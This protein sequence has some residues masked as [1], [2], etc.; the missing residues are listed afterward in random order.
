LKSLVAQMCIN[1][2]EKP[3]SFM[4]D[5]LRKNYLDS[6]EMDVSADTEVLE[7]FPVKTGQKRQLRAR[8]R[9]GAFSSEATKDVNLDAEPI[10]VVPKSA[11][12]K[13]RLAKALSINILFSH[14]DDAEREEIF[15]AMSEVSFDAGDVII[16]QGDDHGDHFYVVDEGECEIFVTSPQGVRTKVAHVDSGG[17]FGELALIYG[18]SRAADVIA[19]TKV[20]LWAID[21]ITYRRI[22]MGA[23][24]RKREQFRAFL[25]KVPIL[26]SLTDYERLTVAD[27][28][29]GA[30]FEK[31]EVIVRQGEPGNVFYIIMEGEA[32]VHK[33]EDDKQEEVGHLSASDYFG[34]IALI[35]NKPRAATV[36]ALTPLKCVKLDRDRFNRVLGPCEDILRRNISNYRKY[37]PEVEQ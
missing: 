18:T 4:V 17:S 24:L 32:S 6:E 21:R 2:P 20:Q 16:K 31:G 11:S 8:C 10:A 5:F 37:M 12:T 33:V 26:E 28:L 22:L 9:R 19:K 13:Q 1:K 29:E 15:D 27:A 25:A 34:E 3:V 23:T 30:N 7:P 35:T 14:L 36:T